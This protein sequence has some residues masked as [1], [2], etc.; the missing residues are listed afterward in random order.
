[1]FDALSAQMDDKETVSEEALENGAVEPARLFPDPNG[2]DWGPEKNNATLIINPAT[3]EIKGPMAIDVETDEADNFVGAALCGG[4]TVYYYTDIKLLSFHVENH[5]GM[6]DADAE[7]VG[8]NLKGDIKWLKKWGLNLGSTNIFYDTMIASYVVNPIRVSHGLKPLAKEL[9]SMTWPTYAQI[10]GKGKKRITLD[11]Q[12]V[13]LVARYCGMDCLATWRLYKFFQS[14][15]TPG[16]RRIFDGVEMPVNRLLYRM[17]DKGVNINTALLT[18]LDTEFSAKILEILEL[19]RTMTEKDIEGL[20]LKYRVEQLKDKWQ[21]SGLKAFEKNK[22]LNPG[23]WQ[24]KRLLLKYLGLEIDTT[25]RRTLKKFKDKYQLINVLLE[26]S[27]FAKLYNT[28]IKA[29]K[30]LSTL[31]TIH[32]TYNQVSEDADD[33]DDM[34]GIRTG[35]L[36]AKQPNLQQ[37]PR[38]SVEGN[39]LRELFI[40]RPEEVFVVADYSQIELRLAAHFSHDPILLSA[41]KNGED[42]HDATA[43][44]LG[45]D[46]DF[47]K[48]ANFLLAFGGSHYRLMDE[49]NLSEDRAREFYQHYWRTFKRLGFWKSVALKTARRQGGVTTIIGRWIPV[50]NM[51]A[52]SPYARGKAERQT[53]SKIIQGSAADI[54]KLAMLECAKRG[55]E[56][57]LTVHDELVVGVKDFMPWEDAK[58]ITKIMEAVVPMDIPLTAEVGVGINWAHAKGNHEKKAA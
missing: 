51:D 53:I 18:Q 55:Y 26:H 24:Q 21:M 43:K 22:K 27:K 44:A 40:P 36:S 13:G 12:T 58:A 39:K 49:L 2:D 45:V 20:L 29:F 16:Q 56:P 1:M 42:I 19:V 37:I 6:A 15:M 3:I 4:N 28:F 34:H 23:S 11:K 31:P 54:I 25:D 10:V 5:D 14:K 46:R 8:H 41:F 52:S 35:R 48:Q 57:T 50:E 30:E 33:E 7:L 47:G 17:E 38:R 32:T 9:L